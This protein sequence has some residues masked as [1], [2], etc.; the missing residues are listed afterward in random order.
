V[1]PV[2]STDLRAEDIRWDL[3]DLCSD[4]EEARV[5][6]TALVQRAQELATRY[7]GEIA[8]LD[9]P[10]LREMF[11]EADDLE[12]ELSR[13]QVYS[14][15]RLS[16]AAAE[17]EANDL[18]TFTRDRGAE[19]ENALVFLGLEWI[20]LDDER[21]ESLLAAPELAPYEHKLRVERQ[22]KPYVL[23]EPEEQALNARRPTVTAWQA[24]HDRHVSTLEV[25]FDAGEGEQ[26]HT[27]SQLLSHM[28]RPDRDVRLRAV[29]ALYEA[30]APRADV[31]AA[32]YDALVGDRLSTDRL[33]GYANPMQPT[34]MSNELDDETV[35][36][37]MAAI[38]EAYPIARKWFEAKAR[39]LSLEKLELA[40]QYAPIGDARSFPWSEAVDIVD[41]SF[42]RFSPRLADIFRSCIEAGHVDVLPRAG[43]AG[44]AYCTSVSKHI[45]PYVLMN[46]TERLRDV[47]TLAHEFGHATHNVLAL[48][49]QTWRSHRTGIPM[50]EVPSTFAQALADDYLLQNETDPGT[51]AALAADRL[52]NAFAAIFRQ[53][54]LARFEQRAYA[55]RSDGRSLAAERLNEL[56]V[57]ENGKY[58]GDALVMPEGYAYGWSYIPHFIHVRFYTYAYSFAQLVALLLYRRYRQDA[59]EFAPK[60]LALL[61]A[62][63]SASPADLVAP[64]G[65]DLRSIETWREAFAELDALR[66]DADTL[67][68]QA[69]Q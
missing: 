51:R 23:S 17:V 58:Y 40:D 61:G 3:T 38:E 27:I 47:S 7:R 28:Y 36:A 52:E 18:A 9:A 21:A 55:L 14:Y 39:L 20:A 22:E 65:L 4:A 54:V 37:M 64:F 5:Q 11:D 2:T 16:M 48:E 60:Y 19:I 67:A 8:S 42:G 15:L 12:Q 62:G 29:T 68:S 25:P 10:A 43:K 35:E 46:Y 26:P 32:A 34:N 69:A 49:Q 33:R 31:L 24:L 50:A 53:T 6:W 63:G 57:D 1:L 45:L 56:W 66:E 13:L 30:L 41:T 59:E 44:G